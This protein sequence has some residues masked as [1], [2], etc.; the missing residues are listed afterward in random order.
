MLYNFEL[1]M[2]GVLLIPAMIAAGIFMWFKRR[3]S[4]QELSDV[5]NTDSA[6]I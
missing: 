6:N 4:N 2:L 3:K 5:E 1:Q